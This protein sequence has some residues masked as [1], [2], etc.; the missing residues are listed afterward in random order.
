MIVHHSIKNITPTIRSVKEVL[1]DLI[2]NIQLKSLTPKEIIE[3]VAKFDISYKDIIGSSRKKEL[4]FG[5]DKLLF[6]LIR[7]IKHLSNYWSRTWW[8]RPHYLCMLIVK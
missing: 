4:V 1:S 7:R 6:I 3:S 8:K 2:T 5:Q